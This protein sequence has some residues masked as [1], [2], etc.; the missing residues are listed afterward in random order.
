M[1]DSATVE[2]SQQQLDRLSQQFSDEDWKEF[3]ELTA[4]DFEQHDPECAKIIRRSANPRQSPF[5]RAKAISVMLA[6]MQRGSQSGGQ[7]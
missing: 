7:S 2:Y 4:R 1:P 6:E 3:Q 5:I